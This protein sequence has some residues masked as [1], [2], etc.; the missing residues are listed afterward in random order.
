MALQL[1]RRSPK[2]RVLLFSTDPAHSLADCLGQTIEEHITAVCGQANLLIYEINPTH[3]FEPFRH[4][5]VEEMAALFVAVTAQGQLDAP[6][7]RQVMT[8]LMDLIPPEIDEIMSLIEITSIVR[9]KAYDYYIYYILDNAPTGHLLR[10]LELPELMQDWV[11]IFFLLILKYS[12]VAQLPNTSTMLVQMSAGDDRR[13]ADCANRRRSPSPDPK[14]PLW[15]GAR[16][17]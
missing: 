9:H 7:D 1:A 4:T 2:K 6:F 14:C 12:R 10:F 3:L 16:H 15:S 5:Y 13:H 11:R 17:P 8:H